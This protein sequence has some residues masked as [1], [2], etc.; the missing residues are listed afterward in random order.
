MTTTVTAP[1][2]AAR[3]RRLVADAFAEQNRRR[4]AGRD[5]T[6]L[7]MSGLGG[8]TRAAAYSIAGTPPSDTPPEQEARQALLGTLIHEGLLPT[9]AELLGDDA[10]HE[11]PVTVTGGGLTITGTL[12]L[13]HGATV[14]DVKSVREFRLRGVRMLGT[15]SE[16][17]IQVLG[18]ALGRYQAGHP[19]EWVSWIYIDRSTG[20]VHIESEPFT[21][22]AALA[23][24]NRLEEIAQFATNDPDQAPRRTIRG[25]RRSGMRGPGLSYQCDR[26]PW[27]R[28]CWGDDATPGEV[29]AQTTVART[30]AGV[31]YALAL[32]AAGADAASTG[33][34][35]QEFAKA[36]LAK[37]PPGTYGNWVYRVGDPGTT[38]DNEAIRADYAARGLPV[39]TKPTAGQTQVKRA[40]Q[41]P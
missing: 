38:W 3:T 21:N 10:V 25:E 32:Y 26:C 34:A 23:V 12:D 27:L 20:E 40:P 2:V 30:D 36:I 35:D 5:P 6:R 15:Y 14:W 19:V 11:S 18:Y 9:M 16:H 7:T 22:A 41:L 31:E 1:D 24:I 17:R 4:Q 28:R 37:T 33:R 8:C 39:P 13:A 29:G